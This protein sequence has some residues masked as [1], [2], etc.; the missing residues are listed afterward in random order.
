MTQHRRRLVEG[1]PKA[2]CFR[3][4]V[5]GTLWFKD[6][7]VV[8]KKD[9]PKKKILDEAHTLKYSIHPGSSKMYHDLR[10]QF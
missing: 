9:A 7:I 2:K 3:E 5:E 8:L 6:R 10:G 1:D 4:D